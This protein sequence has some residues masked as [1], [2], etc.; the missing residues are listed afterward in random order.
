MEFKYDSKGKIMSNNINPINNLPGN[1]SNIRQTQ[2]P[3]PSA[4]RES[5]FARSN[6]LSFPSPPASQSLTPFFVD[7]NPP[8]SSARVSEIASSSFQH[9]NNCVGNEIETALN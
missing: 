6:N 1:S 5:F 7:P 4:S 9:G 3:A 2:P 8:S